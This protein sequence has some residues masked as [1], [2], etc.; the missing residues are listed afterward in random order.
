MESLGLI[1]ISG[2]SLALVA[3]DALDK[4]ARV[5]LIEV[6]LNDQLGALIKFAGDSGAVRAAA[7]AAESIVREMR[8]KIVVDLI[9]A[10]DAQTLA[11][12]VVGREFNAMM[13][14][15][16]VFSSAV[17]RK[18]NSD[19]ATKESAVNGSFAI[20]LIETQGLT[21]V[22]EALDTACKAAN[23]E[24]VGREKLGGGYVTVIIKGDVAAVKAAV[25]AGK[26]KVE[27][28]GKLIAA[29]VIARPSEAVLGILPKA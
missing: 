12:A 13:N 28:L 23:V 22:L 20:G 6:E 9:N 17:G 26:A 27:G 25:D 5:R 29:H 15:E 18:Q 10:P 19:Q 4:S 3:L 2:L 21:A 11:T 16:V 8:G 1:E 24:V 14:S 7:Q